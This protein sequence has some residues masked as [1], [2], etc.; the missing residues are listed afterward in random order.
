[1]RLGGVR[2]QR[3]RALEV[4]FGELEVPLLLE[5]HTEF[6][7]GLPEIL[8]QPDRFAK[9]GLDARKGL[10]NPAGFRFWREDLAV[11]ER[12]EVVPGM[13][14]VEDP[15]PLLDLV[16]APDGVLQQP[17]EERMGLFHRRRKL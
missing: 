7:M 5:E 1:M 8:L 11:E 16:H 10:R 14:L 6:V 13:L 4:L 17:P 12:T 3:R 9:Q 15:Q 2:I